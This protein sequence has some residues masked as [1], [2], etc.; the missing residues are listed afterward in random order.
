[1]YLILLDVQITRIKDIFINN[2]LFPLLVTT[3]SV[4]FRN[5]LTQER[6]RQTFLRIKAIAKAVNV[7]GFRDVWGHGPA[8]NFEI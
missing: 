5:T 3:D 7:R 6:C 2:K 8:E 4:T 1:M